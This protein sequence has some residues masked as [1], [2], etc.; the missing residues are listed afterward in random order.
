MPL[1]PKTEMVLEV[2]NR[3]P[4]CPPYVNVKHLPELETPKKREAH[5][6]Y[7]CHTGLDEPYLVPAPDPLEF[8]EPVRSIVIGRSCGGADC[9][10]AAAPESALSG[11]PTIF[12]AKLVS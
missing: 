8:G 10:A 5:F 9:D 12:F 3:P 2:D 4:C 7:Y 1:K 11:C 6:P